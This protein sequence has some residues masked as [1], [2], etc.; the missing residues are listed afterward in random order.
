MASELREGDVLLR[1]LR[2]EDVELILEAEPE[3]F[4][5]GRPSREQREESLRR[6]VE[7]QG[8]F[9][10]NRIDFGIEREGRLVGAIEARQPRHGLPPGAYELGV[11]L[12]AE[13]DR[14]RGTGTAAVRLFT[15]YL[16][17]DPETV[18]VQAS[19]WV[20]NVAMR[21]VLERLGFGFEGVMRS[22]MPSASG[23]RDD[24]A[25]Y[26]IVREDVEQDSSL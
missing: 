12:F 1:P 20:E 6:R 15:D 18:R 10:D 2:D 14:G 13:E 3:G 4:R 19:T 11:G 7:A 22:F 9:V 25:L 17:A 26:A 23:G 8:T 5:P 24:Y 21:R 16:F